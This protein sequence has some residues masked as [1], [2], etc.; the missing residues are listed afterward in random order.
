[1]K[2]RNGG[3]QIWEVAAEKLGTRVKEKY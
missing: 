3:R 1:V 2:L